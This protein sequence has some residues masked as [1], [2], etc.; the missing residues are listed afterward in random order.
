MP[1]ARDMRDMRLWG[2]CP[3]PRKQLVT[4]THW[5]QHPAS[6]HHSD[7][8]HKLLL[9]PPARASAAGSAHDVCSALATCCV[10]SWCLMKTIR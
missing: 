1:V 10:S 9:L 8:R 3:A 7:Q 2:P 6:P 5:S 4:Q